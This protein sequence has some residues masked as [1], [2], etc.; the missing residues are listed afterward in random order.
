M[1][2]MQ[3]HRHVPVVQKIQKPVEETVIEVPQSLYGLNYCEVVEV[4]QNQTI[5]QIVEVPLVQTVEEIVEIP[6]VRHTVADEQRTVS[7]QL[8][9]VRQV[10]PEHR[11][12]T[13]AGPNLPTETVEPTLRAP[14]DADFLVQTY[15]APM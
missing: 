9:T 12:E 6:T 1:G 11:E 10:A 15:A 4:P 7:V 8:E 2:P 3:K 5:E 13:V 14:Q